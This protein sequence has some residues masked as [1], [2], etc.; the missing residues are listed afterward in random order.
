MIVTVDGPAGAGKSTVAEQV[1]QRLNLPYLNSGLIYRAV[2][3]LVLD[4]EAGNFADRGA[5]LRTIRELNLRFVEDGVTGT[6][7]V[8]AGETDVTDRLKA[9]D[10][11]PE[12][13]RI[14][15]DVEYRSLLVG[16]Q[17][18]FGKSP[19]VVAEGRDMG[20]VIFPEADVKFFLDASAEERAR[21]THADLSRSGYEKTFESVLTE[22]VE[23][24]NRDRSRKDAPL[25]VPDDGV[26]VQ[27]DDLTVDEVVEQLMKYV[28]AK[29]VDSDE[30]NSDD[31]R[32][33]QRNSC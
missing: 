2:T 11:T 7:R 9:P 29:V 6:R 24:D 13:Y 20:T 23:R 16:L 12:V 28:Q 31:R 30:A 3:V 14:A 4:H 8:F 33:A 10:V 15:N 5:V 1:A 18:R 21:R 22:T 19:G 25:R 27:T 26:V 17:R 32:H